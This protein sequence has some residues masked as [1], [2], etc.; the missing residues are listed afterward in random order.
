MFRN[1][2]CLQ[3]LKITQ[4]AQ[5]IKGLSLYCQKMCTIQRETAN[6]VINNDTKLLINKFAGNTFTDQ[7]LMYI[8]IFGLST[9]SAV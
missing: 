7:L 8:L 5:W 1:F 4:G 2:S 9:V 6:K 3:R